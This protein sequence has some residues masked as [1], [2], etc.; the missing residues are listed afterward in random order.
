MNAVDELNF[1]ELGFLQGLRLAGFI[2][3]FDHSVFS[4]D[5]PVDDFRSI[6][7]PFEPYE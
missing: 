3:T 1:D 2:T 5:T 6:D 7:E 4:C